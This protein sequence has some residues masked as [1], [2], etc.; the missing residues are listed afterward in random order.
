[1]QSHTYN[2]IYGSPYKMRNPIGKYIHFDGGIKPFYHTSMTTP[3]FKTPPP[4]KT[5][6]HKFGYGLNCS[7][8][9]IK[10][11]ARC[12]MFIPPSTWEDHKLSPIPDPHLMVLS[13]NHFGNLQTISWLIIISLVKLR[14]IQ[15]GAS[16]VCLLF[17]FHGK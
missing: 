6:P 17:F 13:E 9:N 1:M 10:I 2:V 16:Q 11:A 14:I 12:I 8:V 4:Q 7:L 15:C 3:C 5:F